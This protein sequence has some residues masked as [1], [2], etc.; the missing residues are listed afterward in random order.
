MR[1]TENCSHKYVHWKE[2]NEKKTKQK[3][4]LCRAAKC[5]FLYVL[6]TNPWH[7]TFICSLHTL[8]CAP[9][10]LCEVFPIYPLR[11]P[12]PNEV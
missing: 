9:A 10:M 5:K 11:K 6:Q 12:S 2:K 7:S 1:I 3:T 4:H 8:V